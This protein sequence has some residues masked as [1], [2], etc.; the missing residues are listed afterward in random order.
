MFCD[1]VG[2]SQDRASLMAEHDCVQC[3]LL[4]CRWQ[5]V[6]ILWSVSNREQYM[7]PSN[8]TQHSISTASDAS[9][10][11]CLP[12]CHLFLLA[13]PLQAAE[14]LRVA[15]PHKAQDGTPRLD[16]LDDLRSIKEMR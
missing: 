13:H 7:P 14:D 4:C 1:Q 5:L 2:V 10:G 15:E 9:T 11:V 12:V 3:H 6:S 8:V 16:G